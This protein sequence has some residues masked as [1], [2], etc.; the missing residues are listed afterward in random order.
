MTNYISNT[1]LDFINTFFFMK[2]SAQP[3]EAYAFI[4]I[5]FTGDV[6]PRTT[7]TMPKP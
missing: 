6:K 1:E 2:N 7:A 5:F 4:I 3:F